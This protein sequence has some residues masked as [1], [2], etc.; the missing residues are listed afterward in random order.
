VLGAAAPK[1]LILQRTPDRCIGDPPPRAFGQI[2]SQALQGL[3]GE[4]EVQTAWP[5]PYSGQ[6]PGPRR[7][8]DLRGAARARRIGQTFEAFGQ[9]T[10]APAPYRGLTRADDGRNLGNLEPLFR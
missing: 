3:Q 2:I 1:A 4:W 10:F 9:G 6:Q 7:R 5:T 8:G